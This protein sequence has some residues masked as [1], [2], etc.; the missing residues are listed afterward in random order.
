M[1]RPNTFSTAKNSLRI[2]SLFDD[3]VREI[4]SRR[5][6][7]AGP[8]KLIRSS[9]S[10]RGSASAVPRERIVITVACS[11]RGRGALLTAAI[12]DAPDDAARK[13]GRR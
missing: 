7:R 13:E 2:D 1:T 3:T 5:A 12:N 8:T 9:V 4:R 11:T 6:Y 10:C